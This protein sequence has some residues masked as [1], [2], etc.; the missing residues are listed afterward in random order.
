MGDRPF[1]TPNLLRH[2]AGRLHGFPDISEDLLDAAAEIER[3]RAREALLTRTHKEWS[4]RCFQ[5]EERLIELQ[6]LIDAWAAARGVFGATLPTEDEWD[7]YA[8]A[9]DALLAA[10]TKKEGDDRAV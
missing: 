5:A 6:A 7:R 10:E 4:A 9:R 1:D 2:A 8:A 3:L